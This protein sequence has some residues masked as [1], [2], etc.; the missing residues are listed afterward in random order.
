[1]GDLQKSLLSHAEKKILLVDSSKMNACSIKAVA[2]LD[3]IDV[4]VTDWEVPAAM[5][6]QLKE[7]I[8]QVI[9]AQ[10]R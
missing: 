8:P 2:T 1:M 9:V 7:I 6:A 10:P 3:E 4:L 5:L